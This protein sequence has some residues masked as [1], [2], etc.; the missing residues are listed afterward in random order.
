M[1]YTPNNSN[2]SP[3]AKSNNRSSKSRA[4]QLRIPKSQERISRSNKFKSKPIQHREY[5]KDKTTHKRIREH[6]K[7]RNKITFK[8]KFHN[9]PQKICK[10]VG[11]DGFEPPK[12]NDNRFTVCSIWPLWKSPMV[13][14]NGLEPLTFRTSSECSTS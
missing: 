4:R 12:S 14:V 13:D 2:Y 1:P 7:N 6:V 5:C 8:I 9:A 10:M 3:Y 11:D